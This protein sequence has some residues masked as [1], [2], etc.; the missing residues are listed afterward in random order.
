MSSTYSLPTTRYPAQRTA[1]PGS[2]LDWATTPPPPL[3]QTSRPRVPPGR[4]KNSSGPPSPSFS[5]ERAIQS[6]T[7]SAQ[8]GT[9]TTTSSLPRPK[10]TSDPHPYSLPP[11]RLWLPPS[12]HN[13]R[14]RPGHQAQAA[15][16]RDL[17]SPPRTHLKYESMIR[18]SKSDLERPHR[19]L[20][21]KSILW[22]EPILGASNGITNL[23]MTLV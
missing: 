22:M 15:P 16:P 13:H 7:P 6:T 5:S 19:P 18:K 4:R 20:T 21:M 17:P 10:A 23:R 2:A 3:F 1:S 8:D 14:T 9:R 12:I 11:S